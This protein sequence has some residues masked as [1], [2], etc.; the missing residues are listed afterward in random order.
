MGFDTM[1]K[2]AFGSSLALALAGT[3]M[4]AAAQEAGDIVVRVAGARTELVDEGDIRVNGALDPTAGYATRSAYHGIVG[5]TWFPIRGIGLDA[6]I[7]TPATTNNIP[8]GSLAGTPNLGDDEFVLATVG[9]RLQ[10][11]RGR[12]SPYVAGGIQF[13]ITTAERDGLGVN[14]DIPSAS[15]P[16]VEGGVEFR[17][18]PRFGLFAAVRKAWYDTNASG[19][20]PL[21]PSFTNFAQVNARAQL[22]PLTYMIGTSIHFGRGAEGEGAEAIV[23]D[24]T[25]WLIRAGITSLRLRDRVEL[26][27]GGNELNGEDLSTFE[28]VTPTVQIAYFFLPHVAANLTLGFPP[29]IDVYGGGTIGG[30]PQLGRVQYGPCALTVQYHP[31]RDGRVRPYVG[32]GASYMIVFGTEDGAF[33]NLEVSNDW[34]LAFEA[35]AELVV[36][37]EWGV[38]VDVKHALLRPT[39]TGTFQGD[40]V[41]GQ[42]RL[43]PWA[44]SAGVALHF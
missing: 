34:G 21:D 24:T 30:L 42:T 43:D 36:T 12:V 32:I 33:E 20:L 23:P 29:S 38:F 1:N 22:D 27:V 6:S 31:W 41:V 37:N 19:L 39:A 4:P 5:G 25:H 35:G 10:P 15:G 17:L 3:A 11:F 18:T 7:S 8:A 44:F 13:Q 16:F 9:A 40:A 28:H 26:V 14:L 2:L